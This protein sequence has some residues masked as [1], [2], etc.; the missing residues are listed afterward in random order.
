MCV[1]ECLYV[2][3]GDGVSQSEKGNGI[4]I[5]EPGQNA[6]IGLYNIS[7]LKRERERGTE[8]ASARASRRGEEE[9]NVTVLYGNVNF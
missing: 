3:D 1:I 2:C 5:S 9:E 8:S 7:Y 6:S 4:T